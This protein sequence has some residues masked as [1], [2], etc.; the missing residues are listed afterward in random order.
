MTIVIQIVPSM[1]S[2][3]HCITFLCAFLLLPLCR[4]PVPDG[5]TAAK[6]PAATA[7]ASKPKRAL[8]ADEDDFDDFV[9]GD[10]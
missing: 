2:H 4:S 8:S 3:L 10:D 5:A 6:T 1:C 7:A 9:A